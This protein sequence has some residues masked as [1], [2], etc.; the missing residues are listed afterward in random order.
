ADFGGGIFVNGFAD[1][2]RITNNKVFGN[3][4]FWG[5]GVRL[6]HPFLSAE[7][8]GGD[9]F[10]TS[11]E[12]N[13]VV[14]S[15]NHIRNNAG[16]DGVGGGVSICTGA[17]NYQI[18]SNF[19]CGNF[20]QG[21]GGGIG[22][23][24]IS[25]GMINQNLIA[26]NQSF[27]QGLSPNGGGIYIGGGA[28]QGPNP[29]SKGSGWVT[30]DSNVIQGN[31]AGAGDGGG[32]RLERING[33]D[34]ADNPDNPANWNMISITNNQIVN[35]V[36]G[37]AGGA[38][39]L[40]DAANVNISNNTIARNDSTATTGAAFLPQAIPQQSMPQVAGI[41]SY[42][43]SLALAAAIDP[44][45]PAPNGSLFSDPVLAT[46]IIWQNRSMYFEIDPNVDIFNGQ[47]PIMMKDADPLYNDL[48]VVGMAAMLNPQGSILTD[49]T[50][51]PGEAGTPN[52]S[53][54]PGFVMP[55]FNTGTPGLFVPEAI[56]PF[57]VAAAFD[58]GGNFIDIRYWPLT[59]T[60]DYSTGGGPGPVGTVG[61]LLESYTATAATT[62]TT[63]GDSST[64]S[65]AESDGGSACFIETLIGSH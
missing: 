5:G 2:L 65:T 26:F 17:N 20:T 43:H 21:S 30:I 55:Y 11:S 59:Y 16:Q 56:T 8:A 47:S 19:I 42:A 31:H 46:N 10:Y 60:G 61:P 13:N 45:L 63:S 14:I 24:G 23:L 28:P 9:I 54:D 49:N 39:S 41:V 58:E 62:D 36:A 1:N 51:Y 53:T 35:N 37:M 44:G 4:G 32:I 25:D 50:L 27:D 7:N 15:N 57:N 29:L 48:G 22:Q 40:Q 52:A 33:R 3:A 34:V 6:G 64:M 38:L 18:T 12:N